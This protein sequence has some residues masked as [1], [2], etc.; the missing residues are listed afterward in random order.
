M[1]RI[2]SLRL[3]SGF[4]KNEKR[5]S[6]YA[7]LRVGDRVNRLEAEAAGKLHRRR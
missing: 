4:G 1:R 2:E 3:F 7:Q 6:T 5:S